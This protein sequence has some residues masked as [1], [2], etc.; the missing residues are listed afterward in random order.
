MNQMSEENQQL[1]YLKNKVVKEKGI[2]KVLKDTVVAVTQKLRET[3]DDNIIVRLRTK[4]QQEESKEMVFLCLDIWTEVA[5]IKIFRF[6]KCLILPVKLYL[7]WILAQL[8]I[9]LA[10]V[11]V[12]K[13]TM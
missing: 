6:L 4:A 11:V 7:V 5:S 12:F 1:P 8:D 2:S 3:S 13:I 9:F 10:I